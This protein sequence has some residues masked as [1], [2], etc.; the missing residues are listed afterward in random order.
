MLFD[1]DVIIWAL[2][3]N[4]K[5]AEII[6]QADESKI[7][8]VSYME[9]MQG[10]LNKKDLRMT[11]AFLNDLGF[12]ILPLTEEIGNRAAFYMEELVLSTGLGVPD[13]LIAAVAVEH[14]LILCTGNAKHYKAITDVELTIFRP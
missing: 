7:S 3:G 13:S 4:T 11:K 5:A 6:D 10:S 14:G 12:R 8:I 1:T 2:H 9:L